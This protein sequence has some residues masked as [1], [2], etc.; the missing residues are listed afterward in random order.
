MSAVPELPEDAW[1]LIL[2]NHEGDLWEAKTLRG[3]ARVNKFF[4]AQARAHP[5]NSMPVV[6]YG[7]QHDANHSYQHHQP[8]N[9]SINQHSSDDSS[10]SDDESYESSFVTSDT[11]YTDS[12]ASYVPSDVEYM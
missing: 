1:L 11:E 6:V 10:S 9:Q 4:A 7:A 3:I 8:I 5:D 2:S 12:E